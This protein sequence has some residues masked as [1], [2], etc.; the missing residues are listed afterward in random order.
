MMTE[1]VKVSGIIIAIVNP[2]LS[3]TMIQ[4]ILHVIVTMVTKEMLKC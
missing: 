3:I 2:V 4:E 1:R